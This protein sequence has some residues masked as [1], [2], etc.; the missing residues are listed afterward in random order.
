MMAGLSQAAARKVLRFERGKYWFAWIYFD[1]LG[2]ERLET[3]E[4]AVLVKE[5]EGGDELARLYCSRM[6][7]TR[8]LL[9]VAQTFVTA[10]VMVWANGTRL[11]LI[12]CQDAREFFQR[13]PDLLA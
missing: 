5:V 9:T 13:N 6:E 11:A 10:S 3:I 12:G 4:R 7:E 2:T 1:G 8:Q